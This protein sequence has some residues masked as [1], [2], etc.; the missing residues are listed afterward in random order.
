MSES[1]QTSEYMNNKSLD[2]TALTLMTVHFSRDDIVCND[3][4]R[5]GQPGGEKSI[6]PTYMMHITVALTAAVQ[7]DC[8]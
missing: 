7:G 4:V 8:N 5:S 2:P 1:Q 3:T 6:L